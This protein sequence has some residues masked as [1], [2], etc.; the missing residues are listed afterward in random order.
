[1]TGLNVT[2]QKSEMVPIWEVDDVHFLVEILGCRV[3]TLPMT[4]LGMPLGASPNSPS[5]WNPI[6]EKIKRKLAEWKK[7]YLSKEGKL[8]LLK[9]MLSSLPTYFLL[10]FTISTYMTNRIEKL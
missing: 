6:L 8:T 3:G 4:Y 9:I 10:L 5:I 1:M 7:L 2:V